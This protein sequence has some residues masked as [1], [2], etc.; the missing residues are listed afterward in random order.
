[1]VF[2]SP[3]ILFAARVYSFPQP[4]GKTFRPY[5]T[6]PSAERSAI[7]VSRVL[8]GK[9]VE[10]CICCPFTILTLFLQHCCH[11]FPPKSAQMPPR[12]TKTA[13]K[14][15]ASAS[16]IDI[17][18]DAAA[19]E[20]SSL[21]DGNALTKVVSYPRVEALSWKTRQAAAAVRIK[22]GAG[23]AMDWL[24]DFKARL[25]NVEQNP[26]SDD[27]VLPP[28]PSAIKKRPPPRSAKAKATFGMSPIAVDSPGVAFHAPAQPTSSAVRESVEVIQSSSTSRKRATPSSAVKP[29]IPKRTYSV[30][31]LLKQESFVLVLPNR[32]AGPSTSG[33]GAALV[34][35]DITVCLLFFLHFGFGFVIKWLFSSLGCD[36]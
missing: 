4:I 17:V 30:K 24:E 7:Q 9:N 11:F 23:M 25:R 1:M 16:K 14:A 13:Q 20:P 28:P 15:A 35:I 32:D 19:E 31:P 22:S 27:F 8:L 26:K 5:Q 10:R 3:F 29:P 18:V 36:W 21:D 12:R 6:L 2:L 34:T 33:G